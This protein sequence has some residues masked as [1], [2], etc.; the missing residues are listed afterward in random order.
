[1]SILAFFRDLNYYIV[2]K[3]KHLTNLLQRKVFSAFTYNQYFF[4]IRSSLGLLKQNSMFCQLFRLKSTTQQH[5]AVVVVLL[6][7]D[8]LFI[9]FIP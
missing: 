8:K 6:Q 4:M 2:Y 7:R 5:L 3:T 9:E 1:M